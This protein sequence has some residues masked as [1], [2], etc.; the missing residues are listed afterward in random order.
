[1]HRISVSCILIF[2][3]FG[4]F[5]GWHYPHVLQRQ[6]E[7]ELR[8]RPDS[9]LFN[10]RDN[11]SD[12][13]DS[14]VPFFATTWK[15]FHLSETILSDESFDRLV[16]R[17]LHP[18]QEL[19]TKSNDELYEMSGLHDRYNACLWKM[20][21]AAVKFDY[22]E[23]SRQADCA[24][25][26]MCCGSRHP[27]AEQ[28]RLA[29]Q[30]NWIGRYS[31]ARQVII[32]A[33]PVETDNEERNYPANWDKIWDYRTQIL[34]QA[35]LGQGDFDL[36]A[37]DVEEN[38]RYLNEDELDYFCGFIDMGISKYGDAARRFSLR[39]ARYP[40]TTQWNRELYWF[41]EWSETP[42]TDG[43][44]NLTLAKAMVKD[45]DSWAHRPNCCSPDLIS[46]LES[47]ENCMIK[48]E[49]FDAASF[50]RMYIEGLRHSGH[51]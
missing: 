17:I 37:R 36:A 11:S 24:L 23:A 40:K 9:L 45:L 35:D 4:L 19:K 30:L 13:Q 12:F 51:A 22:R 3:F 10:I 39:C 49:N 42:A 31:D 5:I 47:I 41:K 44:G 43:T 29:D 26:I 38:K 21:Q 27:A 18:S 34:V 7:R 48:R 8:R 46:E 20:G 16:E 14:G 2:L 50:I 6:A 15:A 32:C 28:E 33:V 25:A 1:M